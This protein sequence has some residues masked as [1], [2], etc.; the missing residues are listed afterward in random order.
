M[1]GR[2]FGRWLG[3]FSISETNRVGLCITMSCCRCPKSPFGSEKASSGGI[4][5]I[6]QLHVWAVWDEI[7][8]EG[9]VFLGYDGRKN[10]FIHLNPYFW[11]GIKVFS[12]VLKLYSNCGITCCAGHTRTEIRNNFSIV[13]R[14]HRSTSG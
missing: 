7:S 4:A 5:Q 8:S 6:L 11:G 9:F 1:L 2:N 13:R 12:Y 3:L 10:S 14:A